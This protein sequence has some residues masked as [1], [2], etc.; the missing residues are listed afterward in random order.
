MEL[1]RK[2]GDI[3]AQIIDHARILE[4]AYVAANSELREILKG[5]L[6]DIDEGPKAVQHEEVQNG[7]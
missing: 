5:K 2:R 6:E 1:F 4:Q 3:E 7:G